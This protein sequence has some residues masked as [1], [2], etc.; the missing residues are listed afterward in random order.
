ML[1]AAVAVAVALAF[2]PVIAAQEKRPEAI[3]GPSLQP[4]VQA[5][6]ADHSEPVE[7]LFQRFA[8]IDAHADLPQGAV[9]GMSGECPEGW[10]PY[11]DAD[12][13]PLFFPFGLIVDESGNPRV[14]SYSLLTACEKE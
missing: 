6:L 7:Y 3:Q 11:V 1:G 14:A 5:F 4:V 9:V 2:G 13:A 10:K 8:R 12:G